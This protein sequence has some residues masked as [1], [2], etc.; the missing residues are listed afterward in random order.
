SC[1]DKMSESTQLPTSTAQWVIKGRSGFDSLHFESST[2]VPK[3]GSHDVL[4]HMH[5]ASL[6]YR[7]LIIPKGLYPLPVRENVVPGSDGAGTVVSVGEQVTRF[8]AGD[9][10]LT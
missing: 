3:I 1:L 8:K 6:N 2:P 5:Y 10:V 4:V 7:D 9:K